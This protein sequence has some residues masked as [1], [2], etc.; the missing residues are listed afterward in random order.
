MTS[1]VTV[2]KPYVDLPES[3]NSHINNAIRDAVLPAMTQCA[4]VSAHLRS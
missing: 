2:Q 3:W 4:E 1:Y